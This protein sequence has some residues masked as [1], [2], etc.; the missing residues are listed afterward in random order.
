M[1]AFNKNK[2]PKGWLFPFS[3]KE[4]HSFIE[5]TGAIFD[6]V[7]FKNTQ[8]PSEYVKGNIRCWFGILNSK[9]INNEYHFSMELSSFKEEFISPWKEQILSLV[10]QEI[11]K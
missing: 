6:Y 7:D 5:E 2:A 4:I 8:K 9:K 1:T 11:T 10:I 3:K